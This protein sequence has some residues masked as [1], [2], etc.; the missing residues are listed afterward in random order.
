MWSMLNGYLIER[1]ARCL[2]EREAKCQH[3][4]KWIREFEYALQPAVL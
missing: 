3:E 4:D 1:A 2:W